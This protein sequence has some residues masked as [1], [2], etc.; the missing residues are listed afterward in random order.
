MSLRIINHFY[1][2]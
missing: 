1:T 2:I